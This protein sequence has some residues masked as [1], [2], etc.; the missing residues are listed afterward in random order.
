MAKQLLNITWV[1]MPD[2]PIWALVQPLARHLILLKFSFLISNLKFKKYLPQL[3][4]RYS[5]YSIKPKEGPKIEPH[6]YGQVIFDKRTKTI[7]RKGF[8]FQQM[9][10]K[11]V[12]IH[13]QKDKFQSILTILYKK[14]LKWIT[15]L[16]IK[17]KTIKLLQV[18]WT[19]SSWP[20]IKQ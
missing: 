12:N 13:M 4:K 18:N 16:N 7:Q 8:S 11:Q 10:Q 2:K 3:A 1:L 5:Y 19:E 17:C 20:W 6:K 15:D 14:N 9:V